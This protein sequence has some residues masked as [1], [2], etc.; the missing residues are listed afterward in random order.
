MSDVIIVAIIA[1]GMSL[2][3]TLC[4]SY[5]SNRK[6]TA[7]IIYRIDQ[8]ESKVS[9]HNNL[10]ERTYELEKQVGLQDEKN[11]VVNHR[12]DDLEGDVNGSKLRKV[13]TGRP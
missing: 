10:V 7:L 1:G 9:K 6:S 4:V 8:L 5:F 13:Q 12:I 11:K 2:V 3:S